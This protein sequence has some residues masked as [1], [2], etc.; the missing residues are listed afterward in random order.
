MIALWGALTRAWGISDRE[1][2]RWWTA[3]C[4]STWS[5]AVSWRQALV[6][7]DQQPRQPGPPVVEETIAFVNATAPPR[8]VMEV[9]EGLVQ[10]R[11][12]TR[13]EASAI[14]VQI[15]TRVDR[16][17]QWYRGQPQNDKESA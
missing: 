15:L 7:F 1:A 11:R 6:H 4:H 8:V 2:R 16:E 3:L 17:G 13:R 5:Q 9:L 12:L 14:Q 10:E